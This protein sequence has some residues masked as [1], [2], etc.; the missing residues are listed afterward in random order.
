MNR[1]FALTLLLALFSGLLTAQTISGTVIQQDETAV[2]FASVVLMSAA[3]SSIVKV[4][5]SEDDG[6]FA[7]EG[8]PGSYYIEVAYVGNEPLSTDKFS[9]NGQDIDLGRLTLGASLTTLDE[10]T[11]RA[12][13]PIVEVLPDKMRF[14]IEGSINAQGSDALELLRKAPGVVVDNN[15]NITLLGK[16]GVRIYING[17]PSVLGGDDLAAY[18]RSLNSSDISSIDIITNP[19]A[20]YEAQGNAGIIDIRLRKN[21]KHGTNATLNLGAAQGITPKWSTALGANYRNARLN[22][23]GNYRHNE[24]IHHRFANFYREQVG[25][26]YEATNDMRSRRTDH[27]ARLGLDYKLTDKQT[28]G[29]LLGANLSTPINDTYTITKITD[30]SS[31]DYE[32]LI[33]G[34]EEEGDRNNYDVNLNYSYEEKGGMSLNIDLDYGLFNRE[35]ESVQPNQY[36]DASRDE[37]TSEAHYTTTAPTDIALYSFKTDFESPLGKGK[38]GV[39]V[40]STMVTTDNRYGFYNVENGQEILD[41]ERS[42]DF[43]YDE[44]VNAAYVQY[45]Q[46]IGKFSIQAGL[47]GEHTQSEGDLKDFDGLPLE[48]TKRDYFDLFPSGGISYTLN[49]KNSFNLTYSRRIDRPSYQDLNPFQFKLSELSFRQGNAFLDPQYTNNIQVSHTYNYRLTTTFSYSHIKDFF[50]QTIDTINTE[51]SFIMTDNLATREVYNLNVSYP[52][53]INQW[54]NVYM[55]VG[56]NYIENRA[57][58]G[59]GRIVDLNVA[60][61]NFYGQT[62]FLLPKNFS[63]ELSGWWRSGGVWGGTFRNEAMGGMDAGVQ[64]KFD[65]DRGSIK[66]SM[67]DL[68]RTMMWA[69]ENELGAQ[70]VKANGGWESRQYRLNLAYTFGNQKVKSR[71]RRTGLDD[72]KNRLSESQGQGG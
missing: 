12:K 64:W 55:N 11:V 67:G 58:L 70:Y 42:N 17:R 18:L 54:W 57:D 49:Q 47:R 43:V 46:Q 63:L 32:W 41:S 25:N 60:F 53:S 59:N 31:N 39:G 14:N 69:G 61:A 72:E 29:I 28:L 26:V 38:I 22:V 37:L 4:G 1:L 27:G 19:S 13:K 62:S 2:S 23:F 48:N 50:A 40:K 3:D 33:S 44:W 9:V 51:A 7:I 34:N 15:D 71:K 24:G 68:F 56:G 5:Y 30:G 52:F 6:S 16:N 21:Q 8:S 36:F 20:K 45:Q 66:F 35:L 10:V 65:D